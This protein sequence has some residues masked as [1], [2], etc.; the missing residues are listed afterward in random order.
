MRYLEQAL[1]W[2]WWTSAPNGD[3]FSLWTFERYMRGE[4]LMEL[5]RFEDAI[6]WYAGLGLSAFESAYSVP[7]HFRLGELYE[8][9]GEHDN[10]LDHYSRVMDLLADADPEFEPTVEEV[11]RRMARLTAERRR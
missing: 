10:A 3:L 5:G 9:L 4:I 11:S 8:R 2:Q 6:H 1:P 7:K